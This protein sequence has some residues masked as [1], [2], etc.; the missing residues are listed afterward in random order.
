[1]QPVLMTLPST[2]PPSQAPP[3]WQ[4]SGPAVVT[5]GVVP[6]PPR[7]AL[8]RPTRGPGPGRG[9]HIPGEAG[10]GYLYHV[11][12]GPGPLTALQPRVRDSG[13]PVE[14]ALLLMRGSGTPFKSDGLPAA[15][16]EN[17]PLVGLPGGAA[18]SF[19]EESA[20]SQSG[21]AAAQGSHPARG[22]LDNPKF[23]PA[24]PSRPAPPF[25]APQ[26]RPARP[27]DRFQT[28]FIG[29]AGPPSN[30]P[31]LAP[32]VFPPP[33]HPAN[34]PFKPSQIP[35]WPSSSSTS[36]SS[37][38]GGQAAAA[39][40]GGSSS[41]TS[42][43]TSSG[44]NHLEP[45]EPG[46]GQEANK[47][48]VGGN[49]NV[50]PPPPPS[51]S[52]A[53]PALSPGPAPAPGPTV[54]RPAT[55]TARPAIR[56]SIAPLFGP[57]NRGQVTIH[58]ALLVAGG[59]K[60]IVQNKIFPSKSIFYRQ[61][62]RGLRSCP[63]PGSAPDQGWSRQGQVSAWRISRLLPRPT[64]G[65]SCGALWPPSPA[66]WS[67]STG[68]K[69]VQVGRTHPPPN[70][71]APPYRPTSSHSARTAGPSSDLTGLPPDP[72][73][74]SLS[75]LNIWAASSPIS[76]HGPGTRSWSYQRIR[77]GKVRERREIW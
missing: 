29:P 77:R 42:T 30:E 36:T 24:L 23:G 65:R 54:G 41:S 2:A 66:C 45:G 21:P 58:I 52:A 28:A 18:T 70:L 57:F 31:Q 50:N 67:C 3:G 40:S 9:V 37:G 74:S 60:K 16:V 22:S 71:P 26:S 12:P 6:P 20:P 73:P 8:G 35:F 43:S 44:N 14:P 61:R 53:D 32:G 10:Q 7:T 38:P 75:P 27:S 33:P 55:T 39:A 69:S 13:S 62:R 47:N 11:R 1:M 68:R 63:A 51:A 56:V 34:P 25:R 59:K 76:P 46:R 49:T 15:E 4:E 48:T 17:N 72:V 64:P 5:R 19:Q